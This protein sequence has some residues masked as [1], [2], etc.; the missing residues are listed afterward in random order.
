[1]ANNVPQ[2]QPPERAPAPQPRKRGALSWDSFKADVQFCV[3]A[4]RQEYA[5]SRWYKIMST[6][7]SKTNKA[8][9]VIVG[10]SI[11]TLAI[12]FIYTNREFLLRNKRWVAIAL[13][14]ALASFLAWVV[15]TARRFHERVVAE[16]ASE[17]A[18][19]KEALLAQ[20]NSNSEAYKEE[21]TNLINSHREQI[22]ELKRE[23]AAEV[24][25]LR[26]GR[27]ALK[28]QL[29][30]RNKRKLVLKVDVSQRG[31][32]DPSDAW[33]SI[34]SEASLYLNDLFLFDSDARARRR[35]FTLTARFVLNFETTTTDAVSVRTVTTRLMRERHNGRVKEVYRFRRHEVEVM[36]T[37]SWPARVT[38]DGWRIEGMTIVPPRVMDCKTLFIRNKRGRLLNRNYFLRLSVDAVSQPPFE[39][40]LEADWETARE[41]GR[42]VPIRPRTPA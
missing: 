29:D 17:H 40:D 34:K 21:R 37:D 5:G 38:L 42:L 16:L 20:I 28:T 35:S 15:L 23:L 2:S 9:S 18:A 41:T 31:I 26:T 8:V 6:T 22:A 25:R 36:A 10:S 4:I 7:I 33:E 30:E 39:V 27:D 32:D 13:L 19:G 24:E 1:M 3:D 12:L 11:T 14:S